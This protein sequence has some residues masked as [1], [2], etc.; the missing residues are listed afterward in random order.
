MRG[1][2]YCGHHYIERISESIS[3]LCQPWIRIVFEAESSGP[4]DMGNY[5]SRL[6]KN[7]FG[8]GCTTTSVEDV[9]RAKA[10]YS[11]DPAGNDMITQIWADNNGNN[12]NIYNNDTIEIHMKH[13]T[14]KYY[15][16]YK[17]PHSKLRIQPPN[18]ARFLLS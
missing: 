18:K 10:V 8:C 9:R 6:K 17:E 2:L 5:V 12:G 4:R 15:T 7:T 3:Y 1:S 14:P 11:V 13:K 16:F